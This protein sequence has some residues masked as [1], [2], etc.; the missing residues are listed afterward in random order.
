MASHQQPVSSQGGFSLFPNPQVARPPPPPNSVPRLDPNPRPR[1]RSPSTNDIARPVIQ[2]HHQQPES[3]GN[4]AAAAVAASPDTNASSTPSQ[5]RATPLQ[6]QLISQASPSASTPA[7][8]APSHG[9]SASRSSIAKPP[10]IDESS[11]DPEPQPFRSIF[12]TYNPDIPLEQQP[13]GPTHSQPATVPRAV[14]SRQS[15]YDPHA[16][17]EQGDRDSRPERARSPPARHDVPAAAFSNRGQMGTMVGR[18]VTTVDAPVIPRTSTTEELRSFWK[19]ANG[20]KASPSEAKVFCLRL[21]QLK[22]APVYTLSSDTQPFY[23]MALDPTSASANVML[24]RHDPSKTYK[25]KKGESGTSGSPSGVVGHSRVTD[26][27]HWQTALATTLEEESRREPPNDGLVALLMPTPAARMAMNKANDP[28]AVEMAER[29]CAR[30]VWD[31]DSSCHYMVHQALAAPFCIT[32]EKSPA[33]SR[34]EYTLEHHE[35]TRHLAKLTKDG[36]GGGWLEIDTLVA[37][38]IEAYYIIDVAVT[39]L[40][41]VAAADDRNTPSGTVAETFAPPPSVHVPSGRNSR[42][43]GRFSRMS[44]SSTKE[45]NKSKKTAKK[46]KT[47]MEEF[48]MDIES[49]DDSVKKIGTQVKELEDGLPFLLRVIVKIIK[50]VFKFVIW[51]LTLAFRIL[52]KCFGSKY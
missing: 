16:I 25:P 11:I 50:T 6:F 48:E 31:N 42:S 24:A 44:R 43:S 23:N 20:W 30:L 32:V 8:S 41:L 10:I 29:E 22:D 34:T 18:A 28:A 2:P 17:A 46:S 45:A 19:A 7:S 38:Q 33:W 27:K 52:A 4:T 51:I 35:S 15:Y 1:R 12:P 14:I 13:Y 9:R 39:A 36:T 5:G 3:T 26:S 37:S 21:T 49:Q 47:R 40:M